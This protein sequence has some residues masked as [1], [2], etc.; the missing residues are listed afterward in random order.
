L[1]SL[2]LLRIF[3]G[4]YKHVRELAVGKEQAALRTL[5]FQFCLPPQAPLPSGDPLS[6]AFPTRR[7]SKHWTGE[8]FSRKRKE[9]IY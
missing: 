5:A 2:A 1:Y 6:L 8:L 9:R 3:L 4:E 7:L